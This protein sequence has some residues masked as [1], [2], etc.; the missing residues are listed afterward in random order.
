MALAGN[1]DGMVSPGT[2][3]TS[4]AAYLRN[5]CA[6]RFDVTPEAGGLS[7]T[8]QIQPGVFFTFE[9]PLLRILTLYSN[10]LEDPG[11]I[12]DANIGESQL[13]YLKAALGRVKSEAFKGALIFAHHHPAYTAGSK[14][15]WSE[16][17]VSQIDAICNQTGVWPHAVL[18]GHAHNYQRFTR[19][20]GQTQI[21]VHHLRQWRPRAGE[22]VA[23]R[24]NGIAHA[25]GAAGDRPC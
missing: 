24:G 16:Q 10:T 23:Q 11:V 9:A 17:M 13:D 12:A 18:S 22:T 21:T 20:H 7:R 5:F 1:H 14:H 2:N 15:G 6:D 3:V 4:L 25:A 8:A 19:L